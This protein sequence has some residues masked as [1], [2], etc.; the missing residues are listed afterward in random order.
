MSLSLTKGLCILAFVSISVSSK[1]RWRNS[2][3][4]YSTRFHGFLLLLCNRLP[5]ALFPICNNFIQTCNH[6]FP[7]AAVWDRTR[8][9]CVGVQHATEWATRCPTYIPSA[10]ALHVSSKQPR[11]GRKDRHKEEPFCVFCEAKGHWAQ[12][13]KKVS[14]VT[15]R[16]DKLMDPPQ[17]M[18]SL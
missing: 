15:D 9:V 3:C 1:V 14:S 6:H 2:L 10:A 7:I 4:F 16:R 11:S 17:T 12:E 5:P 18:Q 8:A 13:C